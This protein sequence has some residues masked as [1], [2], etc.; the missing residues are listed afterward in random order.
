MSLVDYAST[1]TSGYGD[2][3]LQPMARKVRNLDNIFITRSLTA[4]ARRFPTL[5]TLAAAELPDVH[6]LW[7]G[8]GYYRRAGF[9]L[10]AAKKVK[11]E[12][13]GHIPEDAKVMQKEVPGMGRYTA[14]TSDPVTS[15]IGLGLCRSLTLSS[16][17]FVFS[18][19]Q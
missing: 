8:L 10:A 18:Q 17:S 2:T 3:I 12:Y 4:L 13:N 15:D 14:G 19:A 6:A 11:N 1:N 5:E 16:L 9:L 7:K